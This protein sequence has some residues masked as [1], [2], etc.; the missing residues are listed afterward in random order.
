MGVPRRFWLACFFGWAAVGNFEVLLPLYGLALHAGAATVGLLFSVFSLTA[1]GTRIVV[2]RSLDHQARHWFFI[3]GLVLYVASLAVFT[4]ATSVEV[5]VVARLMQ[6]FASASVWLTATVLIADWG[7]Q[8]QASSFGLYQVISVWGAG[9]G[10]A[11]MGAAALL[12][13][14]M[15]RNQVLR[16]VRL[17]VWWPQPV[18]SIGF[19]HLVFAGNTVLAL[20]AVLA[21]VGT[22][23]LPRGR[24]TALQRAQ[25]GATPWALPVIA[26]SIGAAGG[27]LAP[28][29]IL[30]LADRGFTGVVGVGIVYAAPGIVYGIVPAWSGFLAE[31][32]GYR[33][34]MA[35]GL[36]LAGG[37][38][39]G[40][41]RARAV[42][43]FAMLLSLEAA[44]LSVAVPALY[45]LV[46]RFE[47]EQRGRRF[48]YVTFASG[49]AAAIAEAA[50]GWLFSHVSIGLPYGL[51]CGLAVFA[52]IITLIYRW[53]DWQ[54]LQVTT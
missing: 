19:L 54:P 52:G 20:L 30:L 4:T 2:G 32:W 25:G 10:M 41:P 6:G 17:P 38:Y 3:G 35:T 12:F 11:W 1:L 39:L 50:G 42:A 34:L 47:P 27:L 26:A 49:A 22:G 36:F 18:S 24:W 29:Q 5:L 14:A 28:I 15:T 51:A 13:D 46:A 21:A 33:R 40:F 44:G 43:S 31:R 7:T 53:P 45:G 8:Q 9:V 16:W 37:C 23:R 48:G